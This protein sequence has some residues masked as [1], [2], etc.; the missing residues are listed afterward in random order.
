[1]LCVLHG[2]YIAIK[3]LFLHNSRASKQGLKDF[4]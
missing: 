3:A 1:M 4:G 2:S